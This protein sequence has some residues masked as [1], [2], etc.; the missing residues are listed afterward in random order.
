LAFDFNQSVEV[1]PVS[2]AALIYP[3]ECPAD[4]EG[5]LNSKRDK[6]NLDSPIKSVLSSKFWAYDFGLL[7][8]N[9]FVLTGGV[10]MRDEGVMFYQPT[11]QDPSFVVLNL[12]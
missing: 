12:P 8:E 9:G 4:V 7:L 10:S 5:V 2:G 3:Y 6:K 11:S 1:D